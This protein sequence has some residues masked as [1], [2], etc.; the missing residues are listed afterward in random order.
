LH[1]TMIEFSSQCSSP[2]DGPRLS[3]AAVQT[4]LRLFPDRLC[5]HF[6][7]FASSPFRWESFSHLGSDQNLV[8]KISHLRRPSAL[9]QFS[10]RN[11]AVLF[12]SPPGIVAVSFSVCAQSRE[13]A[14]PF[15]SADLL[16][17]RVSPLRA[18]FFL[19]PGTFS[20][21]ARACYCL[22]SSGHSPGGKE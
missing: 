10:L 15:S 12:H 16:A 13:R 17:L 7:P 18:L 19:Q 6:L 5:W 4:G 3:F 11:Y 14:F 21:R 2:N 20:I 1:W 22:P 8:V 9:L